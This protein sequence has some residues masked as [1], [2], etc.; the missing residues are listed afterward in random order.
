MA[1]NSEVK[2][3]YIPEGYYYTQREVARVMGVA[4][5]TVVYW[6]RKG[7]LKGVH[8]GRAGHLVSQAE[9]EKFDPKRWGPRSLMRQDGAE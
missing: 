7:W 6:I 9:L 8:A 1:K 3:V 4:P 2:P 5:G